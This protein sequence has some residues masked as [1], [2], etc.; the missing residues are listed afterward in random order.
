MITDR[1]KA[2][3]DAARELLEQLKTIVPF[4]DLSDDEEMIMERGTYTSNS[5]NRVESKQKELAELLNSY[6]YMIHIK[7]KTDWEASDVFDYTDY[8][9]YLGNLDKLKQ[10]FF[11]YPDTPNTPTYLYDYTNA[12]AVEKI[13]MDIENMIY[14]MVSHF[15]ECD[16]FYCGEE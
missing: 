11:V 4:P 5:L 1:T 12:N 8:V 10:S 13:L 2:D 3:V 16:T 6:L 7:N 14:D 15:R 9:R